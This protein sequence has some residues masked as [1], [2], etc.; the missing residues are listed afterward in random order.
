MLNELRRIDRLRN[1]FELS[2]RHAA[3]QHRRL[4]AALREADDP[5]L[6][7]VVMRYV[8]LTTAEFHAALAEQLA[9]PDD[10]EGRE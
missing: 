6:A 7:L 10:E 8:D 2:L 5:R 1:A 3:R 9:G 4:L